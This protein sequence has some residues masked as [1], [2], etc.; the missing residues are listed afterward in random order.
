MTNN[1]VSVSL[2]KL[3]AYINVYEL[4]NDVYGS[5]L[6]DVQYAC[7]AGV[8]VAFSRKRADTWQQ[9]TGYVTCRLFYYSLLSCYF[10]TFPSRVIFMRQKNRISSSAMLDVVK[11]FLICRFLRTNS[12]Q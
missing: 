11:A 8:G 6:S 12:R 7:V 1:C 3:P 4:W 5:A 9:S 10:C 2:A